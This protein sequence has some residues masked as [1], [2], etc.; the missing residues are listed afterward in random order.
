MI[1]H[2]K[3]N[4]MYHNS[5]GDPDACTGDHNHP[6]DLP[7]YVLE[8]LYL[9]VRAYNVLRDNGINTIEQLVQRSKEELLAMRSMGVG[10]VQ[11][12]REEL[13][14]IGQRLVGDGQD[15]DSH[16]LGYLRT[17]GIRW[18][19]RTRQGHRFLEIPLDDLT[20]VEGWD[21]STVKGKHSL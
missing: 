10:S 21:Q 2:S 14:K 7:E 3:P 19:V 17:N 15:A 6:S 1:D 11:N 13:F 5:L 8:D 18:R 12:I 9:T 16:V 20:R 4:H